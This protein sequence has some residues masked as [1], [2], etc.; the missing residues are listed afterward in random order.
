MAGFLDKVVS[1]INKGVNTVSEGSKLLAEKAKLTLQIQETEKEKNKML[2][3]IGTL[4][5]NLQQSGEI[6]IEQSTGMCNEVTSYNQ[7]IA[8]LQERLH[9]LDSVKSNENNS[10]NAVYVQPDN[11]N[12]KHCQCGAVIKEGAKF[13][14]SCGKPVE[15]DA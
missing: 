12:C 4:I 5:Y 9:N 14:S 2:Q 6:Q 10:A 3:N 11:A 1:G 15:T 13:C 7:K 8:D